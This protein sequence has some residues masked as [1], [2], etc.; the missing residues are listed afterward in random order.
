MNRVTDNQPSRRAR[1]DWVLI[2]AF[3]VLLWMPTLDNFFNLDHSRQ[4]GE[5]RL[6]AS[7]P[8]WQGAG[9]DGAQ[10]YI[11]GLDDYFSDHFGF[12]K[13]LIRWFSELENWTFSRPQ[14]L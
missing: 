3:L 4:P 2:A 9:L 7:F 13:Q 5:N 10:K 14:R 8:K 1:A 6:P 12:R 11:V